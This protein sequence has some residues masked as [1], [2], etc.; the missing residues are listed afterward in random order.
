MLID[1]HA[2]LGDPRLTDR[3][4]EIASDARFKFI[5]NATSSLTASEKGLKIADEF[6]KVYTMVGIHPDDAPEYDENVADFLRE[7]CKNPKVVAIG[8]IGLDYHEMTCTKEKQIEVFLA[9]CKIADEAGLPV[10]IHIRDAFGDFVEVV[11]NNQKLFNN[12]ML[13]HCFSGSAEFASEMMRIVPNCY[14]AFGG[15]LTFKNARGVPDALKKIPL[16]RLLSET[17]CPYLTPEPLRGRCLNEPAFVCHT[18]QKM[19]DLKEISLEKME[20]IIEAN[21]LRL[22]K[23]IKV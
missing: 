7:A 21:T 17:D 20:D 11:R 2:H 3:L 6:K 4:S 22:F 12:G 18:V 14:F 8:E 13:I 1:S 15:V 23:R 19:A 16:D 5:I 9:Q 10:I